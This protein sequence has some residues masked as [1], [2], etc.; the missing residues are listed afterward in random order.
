MIILASGCHLPIYEDEFYQGK[1]IESYRYKLW[2]SKLTKKYNTALYEGD[3]DSFIIDF[4]EGMAKDI[5][6][7]EFQ[8]KNKKIYYFY[9]P[10]TVRTREV[11]KN[12]MEQ[13][14]S[15]TCIIVEGGNTFNISYLLHTNGWF[16]FIK[17][18]VNNGVNYIGYS[19]GAIMATPTVMTAQWADYL[20]D[21]FVYNPQYKEG[22]GF[23][24]FCLKPH[25]DAYLPHYYKFFKA[26]SI[27]QELPM[28]CIYENGAIIVEDGKEEKYGI[29][30]TISENKKDNW[31]KCFYKR[32]DDK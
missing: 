6:K 16:Y 14:N 24:D 7:E 2:D 26:F 8:Y 3:K 17:D 22:F 25:S 31:L 23:V 30:L 12:V 13:L 1:D 28:K 11:K 18:K 15:V 9:I 29:V 10:L 5:K 20:C 19:A 21:K 27:T 32:E 4:Y